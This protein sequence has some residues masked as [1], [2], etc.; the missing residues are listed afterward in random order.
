MEAEC[1]LISE[2]WTRVALLY[3]EVSSF[4][5]VE[6]ELLGGVSEEK[7]L[8]IMRSIVKS[9]LMTLKCSYKKCRLVI[10]NKMAFQNMVVRKDS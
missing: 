2:G 5:R 10:W 3:T 8:I 7:C 4:Q 9:D 6:L 1:V